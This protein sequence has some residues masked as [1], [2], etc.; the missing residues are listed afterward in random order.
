M[1]EPRLAQPEGVSH[2]FDIE[3]NAGH[4]RRG[5]SQARISGNM[6]GPPSRTEVAHMCRYGRVLG[7]AGLS[8]GGAYPPQIKSHTVSDSSEMIAGTA[9]TNE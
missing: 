1:R 2:L 7:W 5:G 4:A 3:L 6:G 9:N 8:T